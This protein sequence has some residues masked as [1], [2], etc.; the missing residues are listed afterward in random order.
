MLL[1]VEY[2]HGKNDFPYNAR[3]FLDERDI[4]IE[5]SSHLSS[6]ENYLSF[7]FGWIRGQTKIF[8][9][10]DCVEKIGSRK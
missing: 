5:I 8:I 2:G 6:T 1:G 10:D 4:F 7:P 3:L 9:N